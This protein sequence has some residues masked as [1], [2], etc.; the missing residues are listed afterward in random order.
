MIGDQRPPAW[1]WSNLADVERA[2]DEAHA[3]IERLRAS[4]VRLD[5]ERAAH[6]L[7]DALRRPAVGAEQERLVASLRARYESIHQV[8]NRAEHLESTIDRAVA[9]VEVLAARS[10]ALGADDDAW[11]LD[12]TVRRVMDDV[13][14]LEQAHADLAGM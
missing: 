2:L 7:K 6:E 14:A 10:V 4:L 11:R 9:D 13:R 5:P 1:L 12:A 8:M 3:D